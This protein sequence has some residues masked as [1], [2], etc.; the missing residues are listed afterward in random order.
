MENSKAAEQEVILLLRSMKPSDMSILEAALHTPDSQIATVR[1]SANDVLWSK[2]E[3]LGYAREM[4]LDMET[5]PELMNFFPKSFAL[6]EEGRTA[7]P[8]LMR[9]ARLPESQS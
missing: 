6:T 9:L 1:N 8:E 3:Q 4:V 7:I 2:L 5:P